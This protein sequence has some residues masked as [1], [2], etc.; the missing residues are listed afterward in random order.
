MTP[1]ITMA[2]LAKAG[3]GSRINRT[4]TDN[5]VRVTCEKKEKQL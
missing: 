3:V 2:W 5:Q 1:L 4:K